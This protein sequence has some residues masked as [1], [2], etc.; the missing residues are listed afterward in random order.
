MSAEKARDHR[1]DLKLLQSLY[2]ECPCEQFKFDIERNI[3]AIY[4]VK[5]SNCTVSIWES[6][7]LMTQTE[8]THNQDYAWT[9]VGRKIYRHGGVDKSSGFD[10][11]GAD[12]SLLWVLKSTQGFGLC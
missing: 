9:Q 2:L 4:G 6:V 1:K 10:Q 5:G 8:P 3:E 11:G 7:P 12:E